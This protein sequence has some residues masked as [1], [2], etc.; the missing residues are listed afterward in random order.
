MSRPERPLP[1]TYHGTHVAGLTPWRA[2]DLRK[3]SPILPSERQRVEALLRRLD[4]DSATPADL[5]KLAAAL[6][7]PLKR[8]DQAAAAGYIEIGRWLLRIK[9]RTPHGAFLSLFHDSKNAIEDPLPLPVRKAQSL[10]NVAGNAFLSDPRNVGRLPVGSWRTLDE[11]AR[12][13]ERHDL[14]ALVNAGLIHKEMTRAAVVALGRGPSGAA[15]ADGSPADDPLRPV[16]VVVRAYRRSPAGSLDALRAYLH[17]I[18]AELGEDA[19]TD[20]DLARQRTDRE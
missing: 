3:Y 6:R 17:E 4:T 10:M 14:R 15:D 18:L 9:E 13:G 1:N 19:D 5:D 11:L 7:G 8:V 12:L 2:G 20:D 16:R